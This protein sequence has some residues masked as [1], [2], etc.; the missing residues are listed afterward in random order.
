MTQQK[1]TLPA[2]LLLAALLAVAGFCAT[3]TAVEARLGSARALGAEQAYRAAETALVVA[4]EGL[5]PE[6]VRDALAGGGAITTLAGLAPA[7]ELVAR[8]DDDGDA[9]PNLDRNGRILL[10][11]TGRAALRPGEPAAWRSIVAETLVPAL[12]PAAA[13]WL[14]CEAELPLCGGEAGCDPPISRIDGGPTP[15]L[16]TRE[17][18][19]DALDARLLRLAREVLRRAD[20]RCAPDP[21]ACSPPERDLWMAAAGAVR[22]RVEDPTADALTLAPEQ[23]A[24]LVAP[25]LLLEGTESGPLEMLWWDGTTLIVPEARLLIEALASLRSGVGHLPD[26]AAHPLSGFLA[27]SA[28]VGVDE[29]AC[30]RLTVLTDATR[31]VALPFP[32]AAVGPLP[33]PPAL[34]AGV[35]RLTAPLLIASGT[36]L[37]GE[38]LLLLE[39]DLT[40]AAGAAL[41][42]S[43]VILLDGGRV[44]GGGTVSVRGGI[45]D[46]GGR[47]DGAGGRLPGLDPGVTPLA[48]RFDAGIWSRAWRPI[49]PLLLFRWELSENDS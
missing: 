49:R 48:V 42:W 40:L 38:G 45:A 31:A 34:A 25:L 30:R 44:L 43:G 27:G 13:A 39:S 19:R 18:S 3:L 37:A 24:R 32:L 28:E 35:W 14:D 29:G 36:G 46:S 22:R 4:R 10:I 9:D 15:A 11:A 12:M 47:D 41:Q 7:A 17:E 5:T 21:A 2:A 26:L 23:I 8:D 6:Q 20:A 16:A 1:S 33:A